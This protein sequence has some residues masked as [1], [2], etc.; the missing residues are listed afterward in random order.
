M[1]PTSLII[2]AI[3]MA[4]GWFWR[5]AYEAWP[6][7]TPVLFLAGMIVCNVL[8]EWLDRRID[9]RLAGRDSQPSD[10]TR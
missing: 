5:V 7:W 4:A 6:T 3:A 1:R 9:K 2:I 8:V 10:G